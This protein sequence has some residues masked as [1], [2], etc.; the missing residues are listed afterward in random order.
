MSGNLA[1]SDQRN[2]RSGITR[3]HYAFYVVK[4]EKQSAGTRTTTLPSTLQAKYEYCSEVSDENTADGVTSIMSCN[5]Q[6]KD[7]DCVIISNGL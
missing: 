6:Q 3:N 7:S 5:S 4:A 2:V 1:L